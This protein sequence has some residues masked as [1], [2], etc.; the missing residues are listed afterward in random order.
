M[1]GICLAILGLCVALGALTGCSTTIDQRIEK[2]IGENNSLQ[3]TTVVAKIAKKVIDPVLGFAIED[4]NSTIVYINEH[5]T[6]TEEEKDKARICPDAIIAVASLRDQL[7][8]AASNAQK[9]RRG[10]IYFAT[11]RQIDGDP[12]ERL[13]EQATI[14]AEKCIGLIMSNS[15]ILPFMN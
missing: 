13:R 9:G 7:D 4:A 11:K 6:M 15:D 8:V 12:R 5:P 14:V 2:R 1:R 10:V 3:S